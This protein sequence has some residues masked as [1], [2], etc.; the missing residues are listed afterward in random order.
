MNSVIV[1]CTQAV[2]ATDVVQKGVGW[3]WVSACVFQTLWTLAFAQEKIM[4]STV[5]ITGIFLSLGKSESD[6]TA[7]ADATANAT[8]DATADADA[9]LN[10]TTDA[11]AD[12]NANANANVYD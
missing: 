12:A 11:T 9:I 1:Q 10:A 2:R 5:L 3:A 7:T 4:L 6:A 8:A